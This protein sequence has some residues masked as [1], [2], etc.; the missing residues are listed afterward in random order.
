MTATFAQLLDFRY[1]TA[2]YR[3]M[4]SIGEYFFTNRFFTNTRDVPTDDWELINWAAS[5]QPLPINSRG[6][7][8]NT[9]TPTAGTKRIGSMFVGYDRVPVGADGLNAL[10]EEES[11]ALQSK[12]MSVVEMIQEE[13]MSRHRIRKEAILASILTTGAVGFGTNGDVLVPTAHSDS[14]ALTHQSGA[15]IQPDF[16]VPNSRRGKCSDGSTNAIAG[17]WSDSASKIWNDLEE[18]QYR[19]Q[20]AGLPR[21]TDVF[22]HSLNKRHLRQNDEFIQ[23][24]K[25]S[26][27]APDRLLAGDMIEGLWGY[28]W[29]FI[30]GTYVDSSGNTVDLIAQKLAVIT[31]PP[32][33]WLRAVN[34]LTLV[35][36][37]IN[38]Q[39]DWRSALN[40]LQEVYGEYS[41]AHLEHN[42]ASLYVYC[43]D[44]FG[45]AFANPNAI[46]M[47]SVFTDSA[48]DLSG[49]G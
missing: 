16:S 6:G 39:G 29:H 26:N 9:M 1:L 20:N 28:N 38:L 46:W 14:G 18:I 17:P 45:L 36:G 7:S 48:T 15:V 47:P 4:P 8:A 21:L 31:P 12:G 23:W 30:P 44:A 3:D 43:G 35:P 24:A 25:E 49:T 41:Y 33:P 5:N 27:T 10:R 2:S 32:G 19:Q 22:V 40:A 42:P 37:D 34:G 13:L 11:F